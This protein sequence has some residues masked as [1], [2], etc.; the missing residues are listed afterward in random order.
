M[1]VLSAVV[2][3]ACVGRAAMAS[4]RYKT[5][6]RTTYG[7]EQSTVTNGLVLPASLTV[8]TARTRLIGSY[9]SWLRE[10]GTKTALFGRGVKGARA[11]MIGNKIFRLPGGSERSAL[12]F[13]D[14]VESKTAPAK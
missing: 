6:G 14:E 5:I 11:L 8:A 1:K 3:A 12:S 9:V 13:I 4:P 7:Y 2:F 10:A